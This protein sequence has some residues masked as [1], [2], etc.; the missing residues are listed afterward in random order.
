M[1]IIIAK[2]V[3]ALFNKAKAIDLSKEKAK[4]VLHMIFLG[5]STRNMQ[6]GSREALHPQKYPRERRLLIGVLKVG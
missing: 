4:K 1:K 2:N 5:L 3:S 6:Y